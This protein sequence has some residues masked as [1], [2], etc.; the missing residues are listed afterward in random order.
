M[1]V[2]RPGTPEELFA[3]PG[4]RGGGGV[5]YDLAPDGERFLV[6]SASGQADARQGEVVV[7]LNWF[8][9]LKRL[10]PVP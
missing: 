1:P 6:I 8:E 5:Q 10:V 2:F 4:A 3:V 9:E 7:V